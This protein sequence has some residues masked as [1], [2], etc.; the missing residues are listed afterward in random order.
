MDEDEILCLFSNCAGMIL[1]GSSSCRSDEMYM[2]V[3]ENEILV[4][5]V[6]ALAWS[7]CLKFLL[8]VRRASSTIVLWAAS[9]SWAFL[10]KLQAHFET[11][12]LQLIAECGI[13]C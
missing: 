6:T 2:Y 1:W 4:C 9:D 5:S 7:G 10:H 3:N 11:N 12:L 8:Q 13:N